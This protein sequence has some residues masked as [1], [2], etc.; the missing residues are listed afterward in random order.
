VGPVYSYYEFIRP[1]EQR[2]NDQQWQQ[3]IAK[4]ELPL[5]PDWTRSFT[6]LPIQRAYNGIRRRPDAEVLLPRPF[7]V[8][9]VAVCQQIDGLRRFQAD[10]SG[11]LQPGKPL[12]LY[13]EPANL[14]WTR[15]SFSLG[16]KLEVKTTL[17]DASGAAVATHVSD[18]LE[19]RNGRPG[20]LVYTT[21]KLAIPKSLKRGTY[22][23]QFELKDALTNPAR[24]AMADLLL[25]Y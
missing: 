17:I 11:K 20:E 10:T 3:L 25:E 24:T 22:K 9:T 5:R 18:P 12:L 6:A 14:T 16:A 8:E 19:L 7:G 2:L 15:R 1:A 4:D 23:L 13:V 21:V